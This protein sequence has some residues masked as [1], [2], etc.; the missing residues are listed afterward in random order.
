M[1]K[2]KKSETIKISDMSDYD[3]N[4]DNLEEVKEDI[5]KTKTKKSKN[6][7]IAIEDEYLKM[8]HR[9]HILELPDTYVGS[10]VFDEINM[11]IFN[12][13]HQRIIQ[14][15]IR[16]V[17]AL[18]KIYDE[19]LVNARD[20]S[21]RDETCKT[22]KI[23]INPDSGIIS[24]FND[25]NGIRTELHP[26]YNIHGPELIF[27]NLLTSTNYGK[28]N[29]ITGGKNGY[30]AKCLW[31]LAFLPSWKG[32]YIMAKDIKVGDKLIGD[33]GTV[34][35]VQNVI[36]GRGQMYEV[37][38]S[39]ANSYKVNEEHILTLHMP[40][41]KVI[42]W[43][44][45]EKS[46]SVLWWNNE[47]KEINKKSIKAYPKDKIVCPECN[48]E[49]SNNLGRHYSRVHKD[50][51]VPKKDRKLPI[52]EPELTEEVKKAR[53]ELEEFCKNIPDD[54]VFDISIKEYMEFND[55]TKIRLAGVRGNCVQW[56]SQD[57]SLD[58]YVLGL[59]LGDGFSAGYA[60]YG[61]KDPEI[62]NYLENWAE[63][64]DCVITKSEKYTYRFSSKENKDKKGCAPLKKYLDKYNLTK[65]KHIPK[66]Y[67]VNDKETRLKVLAG[68]IDT[69]GTF[70]REGTRISITQ[71]L[72]HKQLIN[73][74]V[75]LARS[76]GF[77]C[78]LTK[79]KT[80]WTWK[81]EKKL[82]EAFNINISGEGIED[83]PTLL[84]RKK[85]APPKYRNTNKSTGFIK[86][87]DIGIDDFVGIEIDGNQRF[88][89]EDFTV[90]HNCANIFS[91]EFIIETIDSKNK[92]Y[93]YQK[94]EK[95]MSVINKPELKK[96]KEKPFTKITFKPDYA[97]F[98]IAGLTDDILNL[99][100][101]RVYDLAACTDKR[102]SVYF[103]DELIKINNF[104]DY[105]KLY[106]KVETVDGETKVIDLYND[107]RC[108]YEEIN[109]RWKVAVVFDTNAGHNTVSFV[110]GINTY[111]GGTHVNY[112]I[113]QMTK[114]ILEKV[115]KSN[116]KT[117]LKAGNIRENLTVFVDSV[118]NDPCFSSQVKDKLT[119][120]VSSFGSTC[121]LTNTFITKLNS[122]GIVEYMISMSKHKELAELSKTDGRKSADIRGIIK[123]EDAHW[124]GTGKSDQCCLIITEGDSAKA[125]AVA[126]LSII[127]RERYGV[128][129]IRGKFLN[130]KEASAA[131]LKNN[132]EF[133]TLK[134]VIGLK[135]DEVY[136]DVKKLR[137]GS[138]LVLTDQDVDGSHI[139]GLIMNLFH[140]FWPTLLLIDGFIRTLATPILKA[141][142]SSD[143]KKKNPIKFYTLSAYNKWR[144]EV[145]IS[146][147]DIK[148]YKGLGTSDANEA[149][150]EFRDFNEKLVNYI[151]ENHEEPEQE[152]DN[153]S[154]MSGSSKSSKRKTKKTKKIEHSYNG[155]DINSKSHQA[156]LLAFS[157]DYADNRK[158]WLAH[159]DRNSIPEPVNN[160]IGYSEFID[161]D[162][163]H[164]SNYDNERS[165]PSLCDGL[166]TSQRKI[167]YGCF[168]RKLH[169]E[170]K[171]AQLAGY[172]SEHTGYHHGEMSLNMT[173]VGL[174]QNFPTSNNINLLVPC[175]NFGYR[176]MG[177]KNHAS[178]RY[179]FT[180]LSSITKYIFREEDEKIY[181]HHEDDG[182]IVEPINYAPIIPMILVNGSVG[183]GS[184]YSTDIPQFNPLDIVQNINN[185][186]EDKNQFEMKPYYK[187]FNGSIKKDATNKYTSYGKFEVENE[188]T[189]RI[190]ELP[191]NTW[192][193]DYL[194]KLNEMIPDKKDDDEKKIIKRIINNSTNDNIDIRVEF[195]E[196]VLQKLI[197][198]NTMY[199]VMKLSSSISC[200]NMTLFNTR[201][202]IVKY[203]FVEDIIS[204]YY[205]YRLQMY[206][207]RK[208]YM[209][210]LLEH[211]MNVLKYKVQF[212]K[213]KLSNKIILERR[214]TE[215]VI[216]DL[217]ELGFPRFGSSFETP[218]E[219]RTYRY[220]TDM[221]IFSLTEDKI[222]S[223]EEDYADKKRIYEE[224]KNI[225]I[226]QLWKKEL[227][228]FADKYNIWLEEENAKSKDEEP[229]KRKKKQVK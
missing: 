170:I 142:K 130:V 131:Q 50:K 143:V 206:E 229:K 201:G 52:K 10:I 72:N 16:F 93:Y 78:Q 145:D 88:V 120:K 66:E 95:N 48:M 9:T 77:C 65:N 228:E 106:S 103:N 24:V 69:D 162:L 59:L 23:D 144:E 67:L 35:T 210:K 121:E 14:K 138:I 108:V 187:N 107:D 113:D 129:P 158:K 97:R 70:S 178:A 37:E 141:F 80:S 41:H 217:E 139:K 45:S 22:I 8:D 149:K 15:K 115:K 28:T 1:S 62:I 127:G 44:S 18:Y 29:K 172:I 92:T 124:A 165:I 33:D 132:E 100:K 126:G 56:P 159:Y 157:K 221:S 47:K 12:E 63:N 209:L 91:N 195:N 46:W 58:P 150:E 55:T 196:G 218:E 214:K 54:N 30:G 192:T 81:G 204:E 7:N 146:K 140:T 4:N 226:K 87:K 208:E 117:T 27:G 227:D 104:K 118:I 220:I 116:S 21:I 26:E 96:T 179:I 102:V 11:W 219:D 38:Q 151:W 6:K 203:D 136:K 153:I 94:F 194:I 193:S 152:Q 89:M 40:D 198:E 200:T 74:I 51:E 176:D 197:K 216:K 199:K 134:T 128:L 112:I 85:C 119:N 105:I 184:G 13:E 31:P 207:R 156:L 32:N 98:K 25:G 49:L 135:Q 166:K 183:I 39:N 215:D 114:V 188:T 5:K 86:I 76:L 212:I 177:G 57:V 189:I 169:K 161:K 225:T 171:V 34:R 213:F 224:Y 205:I 84:P 181:E 111:E 61:E 160:K 20:H 223:I 82:G 168:K 191:I 222:N 64:T 99:F 68:I 148:Y 173:I 109:D 211:Q 137:Y 185:L 19:I 75:F 79:K 186:L 43:N 174:A 122:T 101:K 180:Y 125:Y 182:D 3:N 17:P 154:V 42:F 71:G 60:C 83:I 123:L 202:D 147:Y 164:F 190:T 36:T 90:T 2:V 155:I 133:K 53:I 175:G 73:D 167:L 163:K 110:N